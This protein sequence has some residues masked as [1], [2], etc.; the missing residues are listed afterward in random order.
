MPTFVTSLVSLFAI[1]FTIVLNVI[2]RSISWPELAKFPNYFLFHYWF[3]IG[4]PVGAIL[5]SGVY[6]FK[7]KSLRKAFK[8]KFM[9]YFCQRLVLS[10]E[11]SFELH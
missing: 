6:Y 2:S 7:Q 4:P 1:G 3:L 11:A 9:E 10:R 5:I 8:R